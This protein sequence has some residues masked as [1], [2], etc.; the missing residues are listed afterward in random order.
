MRVIK[1][2]GYMDVAEVA[3]YLGCS[4]STVYRLAKTEGLP[5]LKPRGKTTGYIA[6][7]GEVKKWAE[8]RLAYV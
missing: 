5:L 1:P 6:K 7:E 4:V 8:S 3:A 2:P